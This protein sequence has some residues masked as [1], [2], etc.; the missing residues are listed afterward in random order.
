MLASILQIFPKIQFS[1]LETRGLSFYFVT[2]TLTFRRAGWL[3]NYV[4]VTHHPYC[5][6]YKIPWDSKWL[7]D[8]CSAWPT[9][10]KRRQVDCIITE[11]SPIPCDFPTGLS[12]WRPGAGR[13]WKDNSALLCKQVCKLYDAYRQSSKVFIFPMMTT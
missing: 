9:Y 13:V 2:I 6:I 7:F 12:A 5:F 4:I 8:K 10:S 3:F 1:E 11:Q